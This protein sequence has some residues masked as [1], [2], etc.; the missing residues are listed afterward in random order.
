MN[1]ISILFIV[2][3]NVINDKVIEVFAMGYNFMNWMFTRN[4]IKMNYT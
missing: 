2:N 4:M 1:G 3:K